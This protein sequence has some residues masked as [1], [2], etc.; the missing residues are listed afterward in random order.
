MLGL[1]AILSVATSLA[2]ATAPFLF[3][4]VPVAP[5]LLTNW[6]LFMLVNHLV[7]PAAAFLTARP[8]A[9]RER[10]EWQVWLGVLVLFM[11][12]GSVATFNAKVIF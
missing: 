7:G 2:L 3:P 9:G 5:I 6:V 10:L 11:V 12:A 8:P 4:T 1:F